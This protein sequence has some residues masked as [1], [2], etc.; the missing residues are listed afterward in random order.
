M[1]ILLDVLVFFGYVAMWIAGATAVKATFYP[2]RFFVIS[3]EPPPRRK[4]S[5]NKLPDAQFQHS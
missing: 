3:L 4:L 5:T 1:L 2:E